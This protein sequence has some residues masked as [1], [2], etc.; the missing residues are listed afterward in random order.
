MIIIV[1][2]KPKLNKKKKIFINKYVDFSL[3]KQSI[4]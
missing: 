3:K 4:I 1:K 2:V